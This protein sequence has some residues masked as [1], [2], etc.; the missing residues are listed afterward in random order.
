MYEVIFT[1]GDFTLLKESGVGKND[2]PY[3]CLE[4]KTSGLAEK[5]II[6]VRISDTHHPVFNGTPVK[7]KYDASSVY[8]SRGSRMKRDT[9]NETAEYIIALNDA[10]NFARRVQD[11]IVNEWDSNR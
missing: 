4:V 3:E 10:L 1:E 11:Y 7:F 8:I 5:H 6:E 2:T 9:L